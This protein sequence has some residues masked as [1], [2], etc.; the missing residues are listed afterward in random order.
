MGKKKGQRK[1]HIYKVA[2]NLFRER[3]YA[4]TSMRDLATAVG[5]EAAS[6]YN[7]IRSKEEI[8][9]GIC[10]DIANQ[11]F[12]ALNPIKELDLTADQKLKRAIHAH[13]QVI[14]NNLDASAVF[15][16]EWRFLSE[17]FLSEFKTMRSNY[18]ADYVQI[19]EKGIEEGVFKTI[20]PKFYCLTLFSSLN[21][22]YEWYK[23]DGKFTVYEISK[24]LS[25][26]LLNGI[27]KTEIV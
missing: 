15:L 12:L 17:P 9:Q 2:Q 18:E 6:L 8:L 20:D 14:T 19:I 26:L 4:A 27:R 22:I 13:I 16:H 23:P 5:I 11:F 3:G 21:W 10:A 7:H 25:H 24:Q 1:E